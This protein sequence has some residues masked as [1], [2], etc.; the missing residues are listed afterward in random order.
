MNILHQEYMLWLGVN[1]TEANQ[2]IQELV[3]K[4][5]SIGSRH[6]FAGC[7]NFIESPQNLLVSSSYGV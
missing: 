2:S 5:Y 6:R 3:L 4:P 1:L 7:H